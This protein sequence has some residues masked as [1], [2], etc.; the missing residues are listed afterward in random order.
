MG[1][2]PDSWLLRDMNITSFDLHLSRSQ[3]VFDSFIEFRQ[4]HSSKYFDESELIT[5]IQQSDSASLW[6][7][8]MSSIRFGK[9]TSADPKKEKHA[10]H[11]SEAQTV[12]LD[13]GLEG[14]SFPS[15]VVAK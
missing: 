12:V 10:F 11:F 7:S 2:T 4:P 3:S 13:T 5:V 1:L 14:L 9:S 6:E 15:G 8:H